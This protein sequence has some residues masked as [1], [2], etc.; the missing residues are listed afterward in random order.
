[1]TYFAFP[2]SSVKYFAEGYKHHVTY[3]GVEYTK[4]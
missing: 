1:M 2:S 3:P 4:F